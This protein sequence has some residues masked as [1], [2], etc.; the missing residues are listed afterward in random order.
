MRG[1]AD[2]FFRRRMKAGPREKIVS[3]DPAQVSDEEVLC[4]LLG[5]RPERG[6]VRRLLAEFGGVREVIAAGPG[7]W[8]KIPGL[9]PARI[10][11][12]LSAKAIAIRV[13]EPARLASQV[14]TLEEASRLFQDLRWEEQELVV[15]AFFN[16]RNRLLSRQT[17]FKGSVS[18]SL[19]R[20]RE[21]LRA[22]LTANAVKLMV[23]HNH[24][25]GS[26]EP[27]DEDAVFTARLESAARE[28]GLTLLDHL[29]V[30]GSGPVFSFA[31]AGRLGDQPARARD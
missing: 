30:S 7:Q 29:I 28:V 12:L 1:T 23:A 2:A 8:R 13:Q 3:A 31:Q 15:A 27:S 17:I 14:C 4:A 26:A 20:P 25:S 11:Q 18:E 16:S 21:I 19:A 10:G 5:V 6:L 22:A 9:G 24:P